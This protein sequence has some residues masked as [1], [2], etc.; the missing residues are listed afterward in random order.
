VPHE[1][2][3]DSG[4]VDADVAKLPVKTMY[5]T[6]CSPCHGADAKGYAADHAPSL[7]TATFLESATDSFLEQAIITGRPGTS[8]G[9]YGKQMGGPLD[10]EAVGK[11]VAY[12]RALGPQPLA[13]PA[14]TPGNAERGAP[15]YAA[16]CKVCHGDPAARGEAIQLTNARLLQQANDAFLHYAIAKGRPGTKME[17]FAGKLTDEQI[18]DVVAYIRQLGG[19]APQVKLLPEPTGKEPLEINP[20]GK[21]PTWTLREERFVSVDEV[22]KALA[23]KRKMIIIDA[24]PPSEWM[25]VHIAGA[26][27][28]PYHDMKR[29]AEIPKDTWVV[30]YCACPHHLSGIVVDE[31]RKQGHIKSLVLDEGINEWH[32][33]GYPVTAAEGVTKPAE[34]APLPPGTIR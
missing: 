27:S 20:K 31:L 12:I 17:A 30:A 21:D 15:I 28:I 25:R 7:V 19:A 29:L 23:A 10:P 34:E 2:P 14:V 33:R 24:R 3:R 13:L 8:M 18:K 32:R 4:T 22:N 1:A 16:S 6:L 9:A 5:L 26:V 11:L